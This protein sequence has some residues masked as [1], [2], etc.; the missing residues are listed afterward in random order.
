MIGELNPVLRGFVNYFRIANCK[1]EL[2]KLMGWV[3][4]RLRGIQLVQWKKPA[5]LH[6]RLRQLGYQQNFKRI[7]MQSWHN[8]VSPL[9]CYAMPNKWLHEEQG[10]VDMTSVDVGISVSVI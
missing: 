7:K 8:T 6:R 10:L 3:R 1:S 4:R 5:K 9:V 2:K